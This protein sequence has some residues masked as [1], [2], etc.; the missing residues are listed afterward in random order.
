MNELRTSLAAVARGLPII[1][2][3][4]PVI[5]CG[6]LAASAAEAQEFGGTVV[7]S[8]ETIFVSEPIDPAANP[9][10]PTTSTPRTLY[11]YERSGGGWERTGTLR[12]PEHGG[13]DFFGRFVLADGDRL[14]VG[15]TALDQNG[16]GQSDGSVLIY[17]RAADG[18]EFE[19]HLRPESVPPGSSFGRFASL[20]GDLLVITALGYQ[21]SGGAWVFERGADGEWVELG[22]LTPSDPDPQREFFGWGVHTDGDRVIVGAHAGPQYPGAA[23]VFGRDADGAWTQEGRLG[24]EGSE[25]QPGAAT[26]LNRAPSVAVAIGGSEALLG[27]PGA[28]EGT[29]TVLTYERRP[30]GE[31]VR[32]GSLAAFQRQPGDF[33]GATIVPRED[34][35]WIA[36]PGTDRFGAIYAFSRDDAAGGFGTARRIDAGPGTDA[37]DGFGLSLSTSGDMAVVGQPWD[38]A[39]LGSAVVFENRDGG[40]TETAKL[41]IPEERRPLATLAEVECGDDGMADQFTCDQVDVLSFLPLDEI[42]GTDRGIETNDVWGWTDPQTGR[43][44]AI[45]G[46]TDGTAFIDISDPSAPVYLGSLPKTPGSLTQSWRDVKVYADHAFVVADNAGEHGMQV[47]D[48]TRLRDVRDAPV[49]FGPDTVYEGIASAHNIVINEETAT[50]YAVGS[51][52]GGE[53]CGGGLH[54]IDISDPKAPSFVGCHAQAGTGRGRT[55]Y[56]HDAQCVNYHGPDAEHAGKEICLKA[57]ET[58]VVIADVTDRDN[59][60][61]LST[62][63]YPAVAY[64]HQG[65]L[66]EDHR[67]FYQNDELDEMTSVGAAQEA[68]TEPDMEASRTLIWDVSDLDDPILVKE[69]FGET[70]TID[71]NLYI[72]G[73]LMYQSNYVSGLRVLDISDRENPREVGFFDTVPWDESVTFDGSWSNYPFFASGTIVVSSG[74]EGVFFLRYRRPELVP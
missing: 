24:F 56:T 13:A 10:D 18:W 70:F 7:L 71:H 59:P 60:V 19:R 3:G 34:G 51:S 27:L 42:G 38:D 5:A 47:F 41:F 15:A 65:W 73:D 40:W 11:V 49:Q 17:R 25:V 12:A 9:Q 69:H 53:T 22:I 37:G 26:V 14:L 36:A 45:V 61:T 74:K 54:M 4:L 58:A 57:N 64:T 46:R 31:W 55:G 8:G 48:L 44:Y 23:Y 35:I 63:D 1:A 52:G 33:F 50:A 62:A 29:G 72:V 20:A 43:E 67:Y 16:D 66:T 32:G 21:G 2:R 30:S 6:L 68:G 28:Y 39:G